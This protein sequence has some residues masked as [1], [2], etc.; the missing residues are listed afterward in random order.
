MN[1][2]KKL[3]AITLCIFGIISISS[4]SFF[5]TVN[6]IE[7]SG[8]VQHEFSKNEAM[9]VSVI[10][11]VDGVKSSPISIKITPTGQFTKVEGYDFVVTGFD[12]TTEGEKTCV[13]KLEGSSIAISYSVIGDSVVLG[14]GT[15]ADPY[16][17]R[18]TSQYLDLKTKFGDTSNTNTIYAKLMANLNFYG[19]NY[20]KIDVVNHPFVLNGNNKTISNV[21]IHKTTTDDDAKC[22]G[23]F[24]TINKPLTV[25]SLIL[26]SFEI[27]GYDSVGALIGSSKSDIV[28]NNVSIVNS[29]I[30]GQQRV[31]GF[32]GASSNV[33]IEL[34]N[35]KVENCSIVAYS[36]V[37]TG[38]VPDAKKAGTIVGQTSNTYLVVNGYT[39]KDTS[40]AGCRDI[41]LLVGSYQYIS[42]KG[43][44]VLKGELHI[45]GKNSITATVTTGNQLGGTSTS[46]NYEASAGVLFGTYLI[47]NSEADNTKL[48]GE[49]L[50]L[51]SSF[52]IWSDNSRVEFN[53]NGYF[54]ENSILNQALTIKSTDPVYANVY[55][56]RT[57]SRFIG[58]YRTNGFYVPNLGL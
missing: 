47:S 52:S 8:T 6:E 36:S 43:N 55:N 16:Q 28:L 35:C 20:E 9:E 41:G 3:L 23:L 1:K 14:S 10:V 54:A 12:T 27:Q 15:E 48:L 42:S 19:V 40:V 31:A 38:T 30:R 29:S 37:A 34:N 22:L 53:Q 39:V 17:I 5:S 25:S 58:A 50:S 26:D 44:P 24:G 51:D 45:D 4:C 2:F 13:I 32:A 33:S 11:T 21:M 49:I 57:F 56:G 46:I 7:L 18:T